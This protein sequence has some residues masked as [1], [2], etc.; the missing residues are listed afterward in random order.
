MLTRPVAIQVK[1]TPNARVSAL[2][3]AIDGTWLARLKS[4]PIDGKANEGL[5]AL[6]AKRFKCHKSAVKIKR[7]A[8][9]RMKQIRIE[10][11]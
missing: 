7:G 5:I 2:D 11:V 8:S 1:V 10:G 4:V 3:Q 6:V 9:G